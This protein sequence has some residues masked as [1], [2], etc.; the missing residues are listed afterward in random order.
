MKLF[1]TAILATAVARRSDHYLTDAGL[2]NEQGA[3][4]SVQ[5]SQQSENHVHQPCDTCRSDNIHD[6]VDNLMFWKR[7][8]H[9]CN[10]TE[11][12]RHSG[13]CQIRRAFD[14]IPEKKDPTHS[15][16]YLI[17]TAFEDIIKRWNH[18]AGQG[19]ERLDCG[20]NAK[21]PTKKLSKQFRATGKIPDPIRCNAPLYKNGKPNDQRQNECA[22]GSGFIDRCDWWCPLSEDISTFGQETMEDNAKWVIK[23]TLEIILSM[24]NELFSRNQVIESTNEDKRWILPECL[25]K[26]Y[27]KLLNRNNN[28]CTLADKCGQ[29]IRYMYRE[30]SKFEELLGDFQRLSSYQED[31]RNDWNN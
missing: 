19:Y 14:F 10:F 3:V 29:H 17:H 31:W 2:V 9:V 11:L 16:H 15:H 6:R 27:G 8:I 12:M 23:Q 1:S 4:F 21:G 13:R 24:T 20:Y 7:K 18:L 28:D 26:D 22:A 30:I 5:S 25:R